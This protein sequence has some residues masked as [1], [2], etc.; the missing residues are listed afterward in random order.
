[1]LADLFA[2]AITTASQYMQALPIT[3]FTLMAARGE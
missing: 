3:Q 2:N 1:M